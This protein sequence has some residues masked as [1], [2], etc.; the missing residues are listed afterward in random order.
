[1]DVFQ[2]TLSFSVVWREADLTQ[3]S[4]LKTHI[5][6]PLSDYVCYFLLITINPAFLENVFGVQDF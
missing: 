1:M 4:P 6:L 2:S 5:L 3:N